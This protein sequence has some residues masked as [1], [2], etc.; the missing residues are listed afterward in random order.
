MGP[1][2]KLTF[3]IIGGGGGGG[4]GSG[5][6]VTYGNNKFRGSVDM[7]PKEIFEVLTVC[8]HFWFISDYIYGSFF[9]IM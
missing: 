7:F 3:Q 2:G 9:S 4:G 1:G 6:I 5:V 8:D